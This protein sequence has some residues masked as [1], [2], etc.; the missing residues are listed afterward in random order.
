L[1][2]HLRDLPFYLLSGTVMLRDRGTSIL[3]CCFCEFWKPIGDDRIP[4]TNGYCRFNAPAAILPYQLSRKDLSER[5][6]FELG[7]RAVPPHAFQPIH[8]ITNSLWSCA[9][10]KR[11]KTKR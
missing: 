3:N 10:A 11:F 4:A 8:P 1:A 5:D 9:Q 2:E 6:K 7:E